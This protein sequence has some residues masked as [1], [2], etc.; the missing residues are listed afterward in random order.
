MRLILALVVLLALWLRTAAL[1][2]RPMHADE[3]NQAVKA[4]ELL[5][6]G[7]YAF[8][9]HDHHGPTLYYA[10]LP[11]AW[12]RGERTLA[13]L[14]E[15]TVRLV[16]ALF[17]TLAVLLLWLLATQSGASPLAAGAAALFLAVAPPAVYYSRDFIQETL[18]LAFILATFAAALR[19]WRT[20]HSGWAFAVGV[21]AGLAQATKASAPLFLLVG[22]LAALALRPARP[23]SLRLGIALVVALLG[24]TLAAALFYS[25]FGTH[26]AGLRDAF[27]TYSAGAHRAFDSAA[28]VKPWWYYLRLFA[29]QTEGGL[30]FHQLA[31][32]AL[33]LCGLGLALIVRT[34][35]LR[36]SAVYT[37]LL[38]L[39]LSLTPYKTPWHA[40]HLVPGLALLAGGALAHLPRRSVAWLLLGLVAVSQLLQTRLVCFQRS[41]DPRNPYAYVHSAPDVK[42]FR[43]LAEAALAAHPAGVICVIGAEYWPLPWYFRGLDRVGYWATPPADCD[44]ALVIV[45]ADLADTVRA[46]LRDPYRESL[47]GLRPGVLCVVFTHQ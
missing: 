10:A 24:A 16:P 23:P 3:A 8:D 17:G 1:D 20:G 39:A 31:F 38:V 13:T 37:L 27:V 6:T 28:H 45:N 9:P 7:S 47:L 26:P 4:G 41:S 42:K 46:R 43:P 29:W 32:S 5:E 30:T 15:T 12:L 44:A 25:S 18:L 34:P 36:W 19:W 14:S 40:I 11:L 21:A 22:L 2:V 33:A 35:L